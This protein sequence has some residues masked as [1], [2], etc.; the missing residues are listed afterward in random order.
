SS[1][2]QPANAEQAERLRIELGLPR[3]GREL[4]NNIIPVEANLEERCIDYSKGC[5]IG[6]EVISRMKSSGQKNKKLCGLVLVDGREL[7]S[8]M[9]L[10]TMSEPTRETGWLTSAI[11]SSKLGKQIGLGFL[12]RGFNDPGTYLNASLPGHPESSS[13]ASVEVVALPFI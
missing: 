7:A 12:K 6:Q 13:D 4:T 10:K 5:Y 8:G 11:H 1:E 9:H 3:W 2:Y